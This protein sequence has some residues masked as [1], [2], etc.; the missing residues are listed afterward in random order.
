[1]VASLSGRPVTVP[2]PDEIVSAGAALQAAVAVSGA[3]VEEITEAWGL[4]GGSLVGPGPDAE[5]SGEVR[6]RYAD[7]RDGG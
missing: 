7:A 6:R 1:V 3:G 5:A 2:D 4:R